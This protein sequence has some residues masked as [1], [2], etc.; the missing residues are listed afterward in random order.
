MEGALWLEQGAGEPQGLHLLQSLVLRKL[1]SLQGRGC[2]GDEQEVPGRQASSQAWLRVACKEQRTGTG[3]PRSAEPSCTIRAWMQRGTG[4]GF[5]GESTSHRCARTHC[6]GHAPKDTCCLVRGQA[7]GGPSLATAGAA[8][9]GSVACA[10]AHL[11][12]PGPL[13]GVSFPRLSRR[14]AALGYPSGE[15]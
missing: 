13:A 8:D 11:L 6:P 3:S 12:A 9:A 10:G 14:R 15:S 4:S 7:A 5:L 1:V 2:F